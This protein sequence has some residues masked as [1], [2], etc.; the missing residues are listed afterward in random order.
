MMNVDLSSIRTCAWEV[1]SHDLNKRSSWWTQLIIFPTF[2]QNRKYLVLPFLFPYTICY[3]YSSGVGL[4][5]LYIGFLSFFS[6]A[7]ISLLWSNWGVELWKAPHL[8]VDSRKSYPSRAPDNRCNKDAIHRRRPAG[9]SNIDKLLIWLQ[10]GV[11][12]SLCSTNW[13][14]SSSIGTFTEKKRKEKKGKKGNRG[15]EG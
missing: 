13:S 6:A 9:Y 1:V 11:V 2:W 5:F 12:P 14:T 7:F 8:L 4:I 10:P 15:R 3:I